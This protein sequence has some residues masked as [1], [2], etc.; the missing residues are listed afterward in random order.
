MEDVNPA[1]L[2]TP[3]KTPSPR[4]DYPGPMHKNS[5]FYIPESSI[6]HDCGNGGLHELACGHWIMDSSKLGEPGLPCGLNCAKPAFDDASPFICPQCRK[7]IIDILESDLAEVEKEKIKKAQQGGHDVFAIGFIVESVSKRGKLQANV[8][9]TVMS[10]VKNGYGRKCSQAAAPEPITFMTA[11]EMAKEYEKAK[12]DKTFDEAH[13]LNKPVKRLAPLRDDISPTS[14][15]QKMKQQPAQETTEQGQ[16][17]GSASDEISNLE[18]AAT[19]TPPN[20]VGPIVRKRDL[21]TVIDENTN[22]HSKKGKVMGGKMYTDED[23]IAAWDSRA[24]DT[25]DT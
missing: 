24:I 25:K 21:S 1:T 10:I 23:G 5:T 16:K 20:N 8:T 22:R 2:P 3:P 12:K 15:K 7:I 19:T 14:K 18:R 4:F 11:E 17:G 9:E 13:T 6:S